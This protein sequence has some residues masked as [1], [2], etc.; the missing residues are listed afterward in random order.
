MNIILGYSTTK[1]FDDIVREK[2]NTALKKEKLFEFMAQEIPLVEIREGLLSLDHPTWCNARTENQMTGKWSRGDA[3]P[4]Q[5]YLHRPLFTLKYRGRATNEE[6]AREDLADIMK[7]FKVIFGDLGVE[8]TTAWTESGFTGVY[9]GL[10]RSP[11]GYKVW[12]ILEVSWLPKGCKITKE[13]KLDTQ[14]VFK[15]PKEAEVVATA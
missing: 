9:K 12:I 15:C 4:K 7:A 6:D 5:Y 2:R 13:S 1:T 10:G 3:T 11:S 14:Y 8:S